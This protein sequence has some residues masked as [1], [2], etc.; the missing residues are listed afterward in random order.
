MSTYK[1]LSQQRTAGNL[2]FAHSSQTALDLDYLIH[3]LRHPTPDTTVQKVLGYI[4]NYIP[5]VKVEHNLRVILASFLNSPVCFGSNVPSYEDN[6]LI[7]EVFKLITDTK[8]KVSQP[9]LSIKTFYEVLL[10]ELQNFQLFDPIRNSWKVLPI[11]SGVWLSR[12]LRDK[13]Y[14][15]NNILEFKWFFHDWDQKSDLLFKKSLQYSLSAAAPDNV[16]HLSIMSLAL[17]YN[18]REN[19]GD[20]LVGIR[21]RFL[22]AKLDELIFGLGSNS[23]LYRYFGQTGPEDPNRDEFLRKNVLQRPVVKHMNRLATLLERVLQDLPYNDEGFQLVMQLAD[24][25]LDFN[26]DMNHFTAGHVHLNSGTEKA[27]NSFQSSYLLLMKGFLF[28]EVIVFQGILSRFVSPKNVSLMYLLFRPK[29]HVSRIETEY[30][31]ICRKVLHSLYYLHYILMTI[32]LGGFDSYNFVYY[33]CLEVCLHNN[34]NSAFEYLTRFLVGNYTE[35]NLNHEA[36]N[37]DYVARCKVLFVLGLWEN[38][39][40]MPE[41]RDPAFVDFVF[42]TTIDLVRGHNVE[43]QVLVEAAHSV[44]LVYFSNK[45]DTSAGLEQVLRYFEILADLFPG[46]LSANQLSVAVETLGKKILSTP[47]LHGE[48][49]L[50]RTS[51]DEFLH[52]VYFKCQNSQPGQR[53][54]VASET[55]FSSAQPI[56]E[57]D[58]AS[59]MSQL[60]RGSDQTN[61]VKANKRKKP[62]DLEG[63]NLLPGRSDGTQHFTKREVPET[64]REALVVAF[65]NIIPYLPLS[66]FAFWLDKIWLLILSSNKQER[67]Y[68]TDK[69][70]RVLSEN[71][72]HNR[73]DIA[74]PWWYETKKAVEH[75]IGRMSE[76]SKF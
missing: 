39:L 8:L 66:I 67:A 13:L 27:E 15:D 3:T 75:N 59:T 29:Y 65:L 26:R 76:V 54:S 48:G 44:L 6:Y 62:K 41:N 24:S 58:A 70:W 61:V 50:Y 33:V 49:S 22:I 63:L 14:T 43:D 42:A 51:A 60:K 20:Y 71:L 36:L 12:D 45:D 40:Q 1:E 69:F 57:I 9:T 68:L 52:F 7:I 18:V 19:L 23:R 72:D 56:Q 31:Q 37:R 74:Y 4:Y 28:L 46:V 32:G 55:V 11:I 2:S 17:K 10:K 47:I 16:T 25:M 34:R 21:G 53:I 5:Y 38:Y 73:C 30:T 64:S 35:V